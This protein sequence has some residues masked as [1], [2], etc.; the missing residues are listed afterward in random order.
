MSE[1]RESGA[2]PAWAGGVG[3]PRAVSPA[4]GPSAPRD[5]GWGLLARRVRD[6]EGRRV[7]RDAFAVGWTE[8]CDHPV[9]PQPFGRKLISYGVPCISSTPL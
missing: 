9:L 6:P 3:A 8:G 2:G 5:P 7:G 4:V 1:S